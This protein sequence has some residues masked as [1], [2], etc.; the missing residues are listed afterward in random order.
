[1]VISI[2]WQ[3]GHRPEGRRVWK[4]QE[5][6]VRIPLIHRYKHEQQEI[7]VNF[8]YHGSEALN[9]CLVH[10]TER[11]LPTPAER[12]RYMGLLWKE[13]STKLN[14]V[15]SIPLSSP[16]FTVDHSWFQDNYWR[17]NPIFSNVVVFIL[18]TVQRVH[19][20]IES[21]WVLSGK[22]KYGIF[23][24][25]KQILTT[26]HHCYKHGYTLFQYRRCRLYSST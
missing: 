17:K 14:P 23:P 8:T 26:K 25:G 12:K 7:S 11:P 9:P 24:R 19:M 15:S 13:N 2:P 22:K 4:A 16:Q 18:N 10:T 1:M 5:W 6:K 21:Y 20:K 3:D